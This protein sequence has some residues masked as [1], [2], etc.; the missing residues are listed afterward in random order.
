MR[1]PDELKRVDPD[2]D[3]AAAPEETNVAET[4]TAPAE[5]ATAE[6]AAE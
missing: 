5:N 6:T 3:G 1:K 4:A 2:K